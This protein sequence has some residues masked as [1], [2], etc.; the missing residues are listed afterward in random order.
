M[1][2][3]TG[4]GEEVGPEPKHRAGLEVEQ[5]V[6]LVPGEAAAPAMKPGGR[7]LQ[8][9]ERRLVAGLEM[10]FEQAAE[11]LLGDVLDRPGQLVPLETIEVLLWY[12]GHP[13]AAVLAL[14]FRQR[15][16]DQAQ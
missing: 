10:H 3:I 12:R 6:E 15:I 1:G 11:S 5:V 16:D 9:L 13:L 7:V 14:T 4:D 2:G 8:H